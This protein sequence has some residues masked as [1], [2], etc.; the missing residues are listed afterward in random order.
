M[1]SPENTTKDLAAAAPESSSTQAPPGATEQGTATEQT[2]S[3][4]ETAL[5][6]YEDFTKVEL[7]VATILE[8]E[9][10]PK[11]DKPDF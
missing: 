4:K 9:R 11:A 1:N 3:P 2:E 6:Q 10:V 8:A 7:R 5:I